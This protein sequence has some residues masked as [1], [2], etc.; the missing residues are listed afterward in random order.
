MRWEILPMLPCWDTRCVSRLHH[1]AIVVPMCMMMVVSLAA[2]SPMKMRRGIMLL[3]FFRRHRCV[4]MW[5][6]QYYRELIRQE[7]R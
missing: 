4:T 2:T 6:K 1:H 3:L 5:R 7:S